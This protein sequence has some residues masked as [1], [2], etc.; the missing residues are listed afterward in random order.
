MIVLNWKW[1]A[2]LLRPAG[3]VIFSNNHVIVTIRVL[4]L[5]TDQTGAKLTLLILA[6]SCF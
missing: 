1:A 3:D 2:L 6:A 5:R 4:A